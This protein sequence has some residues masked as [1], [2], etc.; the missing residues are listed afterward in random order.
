VK[1]IQIDYRCESNQPPLRR[2]LEAYICARPVLTISPAGTFNMVSPSGSTA[3]GNGAHDVDC[4]LSWQTGYSLRG[5]RFSHKASALMP[6]RAARSARRKLKMIGFGTNSAL[7]KRASLPSRLLY[8][9]SCCCCCCSKL[10]SVVGRRWGI[11]GTCY[12]YSAV[13]SILTSLPLDLVRLTG[14]AVTPHTKGAE[15]ELW[16]ENRSIVDVRVKFAGGN[17][18]PT[19]RHKVRSSWPFSVSASH[20]WVNPRIEF[21]M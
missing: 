19:P 18:K 14:E 4:S 21:S 11:R 2:R 5:C 3:S 8:K 12:E 10:L 1:D 13:V 20:A 7:G 6:L 17:A 15:V 9:S 16:R